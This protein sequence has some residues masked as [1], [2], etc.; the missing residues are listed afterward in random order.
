MIGLDTILNVFRSGRRSDNAKAVV[1]G[2][3]SGIGRSFALELARR[4]GEIICA[5]I[6]LERANETVALI[7]QLPT[8]KGHAVQCD[9]AD[10]TAI[11]L[12]AKQSQ[13]IFGGAPTL[14]IN[15][16]GVGIGGK[17]V[18]DI[19]FE[20]WDWTL[21]I[22]LWGVVYGCEVFTPLLRDAG[23]GGIINVASAAGFA[24]APSMAAYNVSKAGVM[25][26]SETLAAELT[27]TGVAV[28]V[29]CPTFVK[30]NVARDGRI[31]PGSSNLAEQLMRWTGLS[32]DNVAART[33]DA[34]DGG[35]LYVVP[36]LDA[37]VIWHL[38]RHFPALYT[39][40]AGLL[41]RILPQN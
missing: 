10:R 30:T 25:S 3:G 5:D 8:G 11:E 24:A 12:L 37:N 19:G 27:G 31:T 2:A 17:P 35:R 22:N 28:T 1:T 34:H 40:G 18:G 29:L 41:N 23:K 20:D 7:D 36:Q 26:L 33:L 14:V 39:H 21:G 15:N 6:S 13:E 9:V 4:G 16:A 32:P 38:K